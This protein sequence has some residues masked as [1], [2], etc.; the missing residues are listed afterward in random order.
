VAIISTAEFKTFRGI[1]ASTYD[2]LIGLLIGAA[3][4][5]AE[6]Y[7]DRTFDTATFTEK[8]NSSGTNTVVLRNTPIT[9]IT[10]V[11]LITPDGDTAA[12]DSSAYTVQLDSGVVKLASNLY[13]WTVIEDMDAS[14]RRWGDLPGFPM[15]HQNIQ[16]VY[17]GG[18]A[19]N[20]MPS[21]LKMA[22]YLYVGLTFE[23]AL[24]AYT[25]S[26][27]GGLGTFKSQTLGD[28]SYTLAGDGGTITDSLGRLVTIEFVK[29]QNWFN[30]FRRTL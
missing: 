27:T 3:Q 16:V 2:T 14:E 17:V 24:Q 10:S 23:N 5:Q 18:Y 25:S 7:C 28:W 13:G 8:Y 15:G 19:S 26:G 29:F 21:D 22:M 11:S 6:R 1:S 12:I 9:S 30:P 20:A 4:A